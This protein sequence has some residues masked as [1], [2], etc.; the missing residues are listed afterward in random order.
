PRWGGAGGASAAN[1]LRSEV[2][3]RLTMA[4]LVRQSR[5]THGISWGDDMAELMLRYG[6][7]I[8]WS[9][10]W[11]SS[12][13]PTQISVVGHEASPSFE[14]IPTRSALED[15]LLARRE[16]WV[17][18]APR[19]TTR[20]APGY[21]KHF[22]EL[23]PQVAWFRRADS[24]HVVVGYDVRLERDSV[25]TRDSVEAAVALSRGPADVA[26]ARASGASRYG[27]LTIPTARHAALVS[28]EVIDSAARAFARGRFSV[29]PPAD[30]SVSDLL[31]FDA[32]TGLPTTFEDAA[33]RSLGTLSVSRAVP[34]G[35]YWELY[36][37]LAQATDVTYAVSVERR[38]PGLMRRLAERVRLAE[39][40]R[41]VQLTFD[42]GRPAAS[43]SL[44]VNVSHIPPG[45]Y[46]LTL[47]VSGAQ[48]TALAAREI[49]VK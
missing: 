17:P 39:P 48:H 14:F 20:Y 28:V 37:A 36:G 2:F 41:P 24:A 6:W 34:F 33:A 16:D 30:S 44:V 35:V 12:T 3:A 23:A 45:R 18:L 19:P 1:D 31:L 13:D 8:A 47:R 29:Q 11:Q 46:R 49:D 21:A 7:P 32:G 15:P 22:R 38:S 42:D 27:A 10:G 40:V 43:R 26:I 4:E 9:R 25:F 5:S